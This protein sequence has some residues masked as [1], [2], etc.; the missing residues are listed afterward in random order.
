MKVE[1]LASV[2]QSVTTMLSWQE[3]CAEFVLR[4]AGVRE[5]IIH[6]ERVKTYI[7]W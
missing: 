7:R 3:I 1:Q 5:A 2:V 6:S 4:D